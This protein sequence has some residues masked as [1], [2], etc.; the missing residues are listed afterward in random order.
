VGGMKGCNVLIHR[1]KKVDD[2]T[3]QAAQPKPTK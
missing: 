3:W 2:A 1:V